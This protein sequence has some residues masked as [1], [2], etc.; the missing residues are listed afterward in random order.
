MERFAIFLR[1]F[2]YFDAIEQRRALAFSCI[3]SDDLITTSETN[4]TNIQKMKGKYGQKR[5]VIIYHDDDT[6]ATALIGK[7][8]GKPLGSTNW[9]FQEMAGLSNGGY[10]DYYPLEVTESQKD[11]LQNNNCNFLDQTFGAIHFQPGQTTG[12]RDIE[13][14]GEYIDVIRN[15]DYLQTRSEEELFRVL[16]DSEIVPYSDDGIAILESEQRRILK[17]YGCVKGQEI[18]IED[19][20]ETD[21]PRRGEIDSSL[22]NNRTYQVGTWKAELAGAIN[23]VVIRGKVFV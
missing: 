5:G 9:A 23:N 1:K 16:L 17:E 15:I 19:S 6:L 3:G 10:K 8:G 14:H 11:T 7:Q 18:L 21:F 13:R 12:G 2:E 4:F 20:I 22:R